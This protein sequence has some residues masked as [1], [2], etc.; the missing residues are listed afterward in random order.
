MRSFE[1]VVVKEDNMSK[2]LVTDELWAVV[3]PL[4]PAHAP[5]PK[6]GRP[7]ADDR[8]CLTGILFVLKTGI[9]WEDFPH[10]MGCCGM[11]LWNRLEEWTKAGV[12]PE[13]HAVLLDKLRG[14]DALDLERVIVDSSSVRAMHGGKK[15]DRVPWTGQNP[16]QSTTSPSTPMARPWRQL[17]P[18]PIAMMEPSS[19]R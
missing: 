1:A 9:P 5:H 6:G 8:L 11:T 19:C 17:S 18:A 10:E 14:L 13:L 2:L 4:L 12:W 16:A 15:R 7:W 3:E